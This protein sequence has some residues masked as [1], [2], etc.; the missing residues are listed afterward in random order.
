MNCR[1][2]ATVPPRIYPASCTKAQRVMYL[3]KEEE[4]PGHDLSM[5]NR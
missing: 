1:L 3:E 5:S 2:V 4:W